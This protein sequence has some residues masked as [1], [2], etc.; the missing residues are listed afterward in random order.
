MVSNHLFIYKRDDAY[1]RAWKKH[2]L[3]LCLFKKTLGLKH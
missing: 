1:W 2:E 3:T